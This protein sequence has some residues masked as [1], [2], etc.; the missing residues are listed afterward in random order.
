MDSLKQEIAAAAAALIVDEGMEAGSAKRQ[1]VRALRLPPRVALPDAAQLDAAVREHIALFHADTQP[2]E[3]RL[4]RQHAAVWMARLAAY[5]PL[6]GGP[7]WHGTA[8]R[9]TDIVLHLFS[10]D[11]K[12]IEI[13]LLNQGVDFEVGEHTGLRG[14]PVDVLSVHDREPA[15]QPPVVV[16]HLVVNDGQAQRGA[17]LPDALGRKPRGALKDLKRLMEQE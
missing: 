4:L 17:L 1:A 15:W 3:L 5:E 10:D 7:V 9:W 2:V 11:P 6:L 16:V 14:Q 12:A 8:N 13:E